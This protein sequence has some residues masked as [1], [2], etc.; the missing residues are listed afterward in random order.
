MCGRVV[1][2]RSAAELAE[3]FDAEEVEPAAS[4]IPPRWNVAPLSPLLVVVSAD[5]LHAPGLG[6]P[7]GNGRVGRAVA[8]ARWGL[9]PPFADDPSFGSRAINARAETLAQRP[10]FRGALARRRCVVPVDAFYEWT[11]PAVST[12]PPRRRLPY[13]C[14]RR[15]G[16]PLALAGLWEEWSKAGEALRTCTIVTTAADAVVG[17]LHDRMPA[18]LDPTGIERWLGPEPPEPAELRELLKPAPDDLL[19]CYPVD[20]RV[21]DARYDDPACCEPLP[22]PTP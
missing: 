12:R 2:A 1:A 4:S 10:A 6:R 8:V 18:V 16:R 9:V 3:I 20:I 21:N 22:A 5:A 17:A 13:C 7:G 14:R 11:A 19:E 15:D